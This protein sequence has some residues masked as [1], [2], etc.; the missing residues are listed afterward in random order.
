MRKNSASFLTMVIVLIFNWGCGTSY[1][2][3]Y[4]E[5]IMR[6]SSSSQK[7]SEDLKKK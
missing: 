1:S 7:E 6:N 2:S 4:L 3:K 5:H